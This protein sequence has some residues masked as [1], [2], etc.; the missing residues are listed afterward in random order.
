MN[1]SKDYYSSLTKEIGIPGEY[2]YTDLKQTLE[3]ERLDP[4]SNYVNE[5]KKKKKKTKMKSNVS[6]AGKTIWLT[7][8]PCSGKTT[9]ALEV[10]RLYTREL[11][12]LDGD[13]VRNTLCS[14][15]DFSEESR[16]ENLRR[17]STMAD[18]LNKQGFNVICSFVSPTIEIRKI[19]FDNIDNLIMFTCSADV[20]TCKERDVKGMYKKA[21]EGTIKNF[22]G[23]DA[24]YEIDKEH[25]IILNTM[26][27]SVKESAWE[28]I[29]YLK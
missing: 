3:K 15:L 5:K 20:K 8:L 11:V 14:D 17:I 1:H 27:V 12:H 24:P 22:T 6:K 16:I 13:I 23:V 2:A 18:I 7:G 29:D 4:I 25:T 21:S 26:D 19:I 28:L 9:I 10:K